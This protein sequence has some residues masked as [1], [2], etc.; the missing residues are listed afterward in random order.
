MFLWY[1]YARI[2][3]LKEN[4]MKKILALL[5]AALMLLGCSCAANPDAV[6]G[7][8]E[9]VADTAAPENDGGQTK[10]SVRE[11]T[12][13]MLTSVDAIYLRAGKH[14]NKTYSELTSEFGTKGTIEAKKDSDLVKYNDAFREFYI[15]F[16]LSGLG[17][18]T[19]KFESAKL[20]FSIK[21]ID[22]TVDFSVYEIDLGADVDFSAL[23]W[24]T[25]PMGSLIAENYRL[26]EVD[27][28]NIIEAVWDAV[29]FNDGI[30][31]LRFEQTIKS[32]AETS[33]ANSV[34]LMLSS[35]SDTGAYIYSLTNDGGKNREIWNYAQ[36]CFDEWYPRYE[37]V[38]AKKESDPEIALIES[39]ES[40]YTMIVNS[41][42]SVPDGKLSENKT[43]TFSAL[44]DLSE[45]VDITAE[46]EYDKYG[47]I[48]DN[49]LRQE[50]TGFFYAKKIGD[51]WW[52]IDPL[53]YPCYIRSM[54]GVTIEYTSGSPNQR[55]SALRKFGSPEKW[56]L[57][58]VRHLKDDLGFNLTAAGDSYAT[59]YVE[60]G[61]FSQVAVGGF[62]GAY[63]IDLGINENQGGSTVFTENNTM[64]VFDPAFVTY[65]DNSAKKSLP[66]YAGNN[67]II[68]FTTDNELPMQKTLLLDY[69]TLDPTKAVN[70]YSYAAA[71]TWLVNM[72]GK[73]LPTEEDV[74]DEL[75]ELFRGFVWDRYYNVVC[76]AV[77]KYDSEHMILGTRFL[78]GVKD[79]EWVLRFANLYLDCITINWY[80]AWQPEAED[81]KRMSTYGDLPIMITEFYAKAEECEGNLSNY[82]GAGFFVKTQNDRGYF[83][84]NFTLRLLECKNVVGWHWF[85]YID[86]DPEGSS[87]DIS[88]RDSNKGIVSN[89]HTEYT[90]LTEKMAEINKNAYN[91]IDYFD[92]KY[93]K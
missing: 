6:D 61:L 51:R 24:N 79:A 69:L 28:P 1:N 75:S 35:E 67:S 7:D 16:D 58:T 60:D 48:I 31:T 36:Q 80:G 71:W 42:G 85:Q 49:A 55:S 33:V 59:Y 15:K 45:Y 81:L 23:T 19:Y 34:K 76:G 9:S 90:D 46:Q 57:A 91:L 27:A 82:D 14:A 77:R 93:S 56:G 41:Y 12:N 13:K 43:R 78:H 20:I 26:G 65:C 68:G 66:S 70:H 8:N 29:D 4:N 40:Q 73:E 83:Y 32:I 74:T 11:A 10:I 5:L 89:T 50:S 84:Q 63:G 92:T 38:L 3:Y 62:A 37:Q 18:E 39:D 87:A 88:S 47:G 86:N 17:R 72:T 44:D 25:R 22:S 64:P 52:V 2:F 30:L 21:E 54:Y 53:G